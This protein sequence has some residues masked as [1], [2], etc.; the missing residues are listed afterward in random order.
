MSESW[1][2]VVFEGDVRAIRGNPHKIESPFGTVQK[3]DASDVLA[4]NARLTAEVERLKAEALFTA[5]SE[6][7]EKDAEITR[8]TARVEELEA[9]VRTASDMN[10]VYEG[11]LQE[12]EGA[13]RSIHD[14][15]MLDAVDGYKTRDKTF[16]I[17]I[18]RAALSTA[19]PT[20][21]E[22]T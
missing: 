5:I 13:L 15:F 2:T 21:V 9:L 18:A 12:L 3:I 17:D 1:F 6:L 11:R 19:Q 22:K 20:P 8:L 16:A 4:E 7:P 14:T 10:E